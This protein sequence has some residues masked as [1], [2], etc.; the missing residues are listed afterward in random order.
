LGERGVDEMII[1]KLFL[2]Q[3]QRMSTVLKWLRE[4]TNIGPVFKGS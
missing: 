4:G 1:S 2:K 3:A